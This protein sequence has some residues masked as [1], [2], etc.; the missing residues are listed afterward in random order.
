[1]PPLAWVALFVLGMIATAR[2]FPKTRAAFPGRV[3][4]AYAL[5]AAGVAVAG[6]GVLAFRRH[7]T[8]VD[9]TR[10]DAASTLV[11]GGIFR[12]TRNPMYVGMAVAVAGIGLRTGSLIA[13]SLAPVFVLALTHFQIEPEKA[14][15]RHLFGRLTTPTP[16]ACRA[17]CWSDSQ[18]PVP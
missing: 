15:M 1:M 18:A 16:R 10:L 5:V 11:T 17:G 3:T 4:L 12:V 9:P 2:L 13:L 8:T 14:A 7:R 6:A